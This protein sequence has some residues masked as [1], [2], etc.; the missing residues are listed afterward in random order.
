MTHRSSVSRKWS[1]YLLLLFLWHTPLIG[2]LVSNSAPRV[3]AQNLTI[4][5]VG[6]A[7]AEVVPE[8]LISLE[9]WQA[10]Q[11]A[12]SEALLKNEATLTYFEETYN[13]DGA[14]GETNA[15]AIV[16]D[17]ET[18]AK[19]MGT[20]GL[21]LA[22]AYSVW[23]TRRK[24]Y[25]ETLRSGDSQAIEALFE[26]EFG[27]PN[28]AANQTD[29]NAKTQSPL[30]ASP[31]PSNNEAWEIWGKSQGVPATGATLAALF[32]LWKKK[33]TP[34]T[35]EKTKW[36]DYFSQFFTPSTP[37]P[38][39][40]FQQTIQQ[41]TAAQSAQA[42]AQVVAKFE[43]ENQTPLPP[44]KPAGVAD[45]EALNV[46]Y[47]HATK[48][49]NQAFTDAHLASQKG[50]SK[51]PA[52]TNGIN[53]LWQQYYYYQASNNQ[54]GISV[55]H[56]HIN[57]LINY[58]NRFANY[59]E[60]SAIQNLQHTAR[61]QFQNNR[62]TYSQFL[63][64][65]T[66]YETRLNNYTTQKTE[67]TNNAK[68]EFTGWHNQ[69]YA[70]WHQ[71]NAKAQ[72]AR[73]WLSQLNQ[74][75]TQASN[76]LQTVAEQQAEDFKNNLLKLTHLYDENNLTQLTAT[77]QAVPTVKNVPALSTLNDELAQLKNLKADQQTW[78]QYRHQ[79]LI[80]KGYSGD[81]RTGYTWP[82]Y[83]ARWQRWEQR[84]VHG[85]YLGTA[86]IRKDFDTYYD[87][88]I[89]NQQQRIITT[90]AQIMLNQMAQL[91]GTTLLS[92]IDN[93][94]LKTPLIK[95]FPLP[96]KTQA[97]L[98]LRA[99][100]DTLNKEKSDA[101]NL[102]ITQEQQSLQQLQSLRTHAYYVQW[103]NQSR[104]YPS[105]GLD[106]QYYAMVDGWIK[107]TRATYRN[108]K[109]LHATKYQALPGLTTELKLLDA[110]YQAKETHRAQKMADTQALIN[111]VTQLNKLKTFLN[112]L[113]NNPNDPRAITA[114]ATLQKLKIAQTNLTQA[115]NDLMLK[116]HS[117]SQ[118]YYLN[119]KIKKLKAEVE[120]HTQGLN[121]LHQSFLA[122]STT[123]INHQTARNTNLNTQLENN[124]VHQYLQ[125]Q[126][127]AKTFYQTYG[128]DIS[129]LQGLKSSLE[130]RLA[131]LSYLE[132]PMG[133]T[134]GVIY[135]DY[136]AYKQDY[137]KVLNN[138]LPDVWVKNWSW[139]QNSYKTKRRT[140][141]PNRNDSLL[142]DWYHKATTVY[143]YEAK[144]SY[145]AQIKTREAMLFEQRNI[146][147]ETQ[148]QGALQSLFTAQQIAD[149]QNLALAQIEETE[150][151]A[152]LQEAET[153][154]KNV[155]T[156]NVIDRN[157]NAIKSPPNFKTLAVQTLNKNDVT[158]IS[159]SQSS[160]AE[161]QSLASLPTQFLEP[162]WQAYRR[163]NKDFEFSAFQ[164]ETKR[165]TVQAQNNYRRGLIAD[166]HLPPEPAQTKTVRDYLEDTSRFN[167]D[168]DTQ[169]ADVQA[170]IPVLKTKFAG[171][172]YLVT[173]LEQANQKIE[174]LERYRQSGPAEVE[175]YQQ[176][177]AQWKRENAETLAQIDSGA[178]T[179]FANVTQ[180][181]QGFWNKSEEVVAQ[182]AA[183]IE[184]ENIIDT[185][186]T[187]ELINQT[188]G[189]FSTEDE[190]VQDE[191][192]EFLNN[193][194][195]Q[196]DDVA[197]EPTFKLTNAAA[198]S[199]TAINQ[200]YKRKVLRSQGLTWDT[201]SND[202]ITKLHPAIREKTIDFINKV[203]DEL[204]I[205]L[206]ITT[207]FRENEMQLK[208]YCNSR[209][210]GICENAPK[211]DQTGNW[212]SSAK[213]GESYHN[214]GLA[215]DLVEIT[216]DGQVNYTLDWNKIAKLAAS[217]GFDQP[218]PKN[219]AAHLTMNFG[220][221][222]SEISKKIEEGK[223]V[224]GFVEV[225][226]T[227]EVQVNEEEVSVSYSNSSEASEEYTFSEEHF[228]VWRNFNN[229]GE[230]VKDRKA[231]WKLE[232]KEFWALKPSGYLEYLA[233]TKGVSDDIR[234]E[235]NNVFRRIIMYVQLGLTGEITL[236]KDYLSQLK[237]Y[238]QSGTLNYQNAAHFAI[239]VYG[240][241]KLGL[242]GFTETTDAVSKFQIDTLLVNEAIGLKTKIYEDEENIVVAFAG[243]E[244]LT[245]WIENFKQ[246]FGW[247]APQYES[248]GK[249]GNSINDNNTK[250]KKITFI[251]HSLGG[252]LAAT[253]A[254]ATGHN[255]IT[256]NSAGVHPATLVKQ[257]LEFNKTEYIAAFGSLN[258]GPLAILQ[259]DNK[260]HKEIA[261]A[262]SLIEIPQFVLEKYAKQFPLITNHV[263]R[264]DL[265]TDVQEDLSFLPIALGEKVKHGNIL[266]SI[267]DS[268]LMNRHPILFGLAKYNAV[269]SH[270]TFGQ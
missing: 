94:D 182:K 117:W 215:I 169:I 43:S 92:E 50:L 25:L 160:S 78:M 249:I 79:A 174:A 82:Y 258:L 103:V 10:L 141:V 71:A 157:T 23:R 96:L 62:S 46:H 40:K 263:T 228:Q 49:Y 154:A 269:N 121:N 239:D 29:T 200:T 45:Y 207:G 104:R 122:S 42:V 76:H 163:Y 90:E 108:R 56:R 132:D 168:L 32:L 178:T 152:A 229:R 213:P 262:L 176:A 180:Y 3:Y 98:D 44:E 139:Y 12:A 209:D 51:I 148:Q 203:Q 140:A 252:G 6:E 240:D 80:A 114:K 246:G 53:K 28:L 87:R 216:K 266:N 75:R 5:E 155:Q 91:S 196:Y 238:S 118:T 106:Q 177:L 151:L 171:Q 48:P 147:F 138:E 14:Y 202:R 199:Q 41:S 204:N 88:A 133:S 77:N 60:K 135:E 125:T 22:G 144:L 112:T 37:E 242:W 197:A 81:A 57:Y 109:N 161:T 264:G 235:M 47:M 259:T 146:A 9:Q 256:F 36:T 73:T 119:L 19:T 8:T 245:D 244:D 162:L 131:S 102:L 134:H 128:Q 170:G 221:S 173:A 186:A 39:W 247:D 185:R 257:G 13:V 175:T 192:K 189:G 124:P 248:A 16:S 20:S 68:A 95:R 24:S 223:T 255:A 159:L 261:K 26:A 142:H 211:F 230:E 65:Q 153:I 85:G 116:D 150:N 198:T 206:R 184:A 191:L 34:D 55:A 21:A 115:Q 220:L 63:P 218:L 194:S 100:V 69:I 59:Q 83:N 123:S 195:T 241:T 1:Y 64:L 267:N 219:D 11:T 268:F 183:E 158:T 126:Q 181:T 165:L 84:R 265:L 210:T 237:T 188:P 270:K 164:A 74:L 4:P 31:P 233:H 15:G 54:T 67:L 66:E 205:D 251:G 156:Q 93:F 222:T 127:T 145:Q 99:Q 27:E 137:Q 166:A 113:Q 2:L 212:K 149:Y 226:K 110:A 72:N 187:V 236:M 208:L 33:H 224:D 38:F 101:Y 129:V 7:A 190:A 179:H 193:L 111:K 143:N 201:V 260:S 243:T 120:S 61:T 89:Y 35:V 130:A 17:W 105:K 234:N 107:N 227:V 225:N 58:A 167:A 254:A 231:F 217:F 18:I 253:A 86:E 250:N 214:Y 97:H 172:A 30:P 70:W 52:L 136:L 232:H